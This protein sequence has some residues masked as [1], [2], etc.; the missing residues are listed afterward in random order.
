MRLGIRAYLRQ[1]LSKKSAF[2]SVGIAVHED[3]VHFCALKKD[4]SGQPVLVSQRIVSTNNWQAQ[5]DKW[6]SNKSLK[7]THTYVAFSI[8]FY[9]QFQIDRPS[10][11]AAELHSALKWSI[12]ELT[13]SEKP[14]AIDYFD[15]PVPLA[16]SH[17]VNVVAIDE[18]E[19]LKV[20]EAVFDAGLELKRISVEEMVTCNLL[21]ENE[22]TL[23]LIQEANDEVCLN[24]VKDGQLYFSRR[25]KG[26]E[27]LS[28][29]SVE[30]LKMGVVDSLSVQIQRSMDYFESQLRQAPVRKLTFK[31]DTKHTQALQALLESALPV[32]VSVL[33]TGIMMPND[34]DELTMNY[35][36]LGAAMGAKFEEEVDQNQIA[37]PK[38]TDKKRAAA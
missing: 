32:N 8:G 17:K 38:S 13:G 35:V 5:L 1:K 18:P 6:V 3:A 4:N 28:S 16:G 26:F 34:I 2:M 29:F 9:Q 25:L 11:E 7:N 31:L 33:E 37:N 22:P 23:T 10:V 19:I 27:N 12:S 15:A 24:I 14:K 20:V 36:A 30:E 21:Q